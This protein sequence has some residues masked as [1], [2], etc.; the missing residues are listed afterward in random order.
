MSKKVYLF[1]LVLLALAFTGCSETE[2]V[3]KYDNWQS[4]NE[5]FID[6]IA[7]VHADLTT[8]GNLDSIHMI[9]YPGVPVYFK[10]KTPVGDGVIQN[11][12][13]RATD[14]VIVY[15]KGSFI[16]WGNT[17]GYVDEQG[18][19]IGEVF[20]GSFTEANPS[21]DFSN[22]A[23][24]TV[25]GLVTGLSEVLQRRKIGERLEVYVPWQYGYGANDYTPINSPIT[26]PG[27][28]VLVFDI[29]MLECK[30]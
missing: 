27:H 28:S 2:E 29:Q 9:A 30:K 21:I 26:I 15:Y 6:S 8:R 18:N 19:F 24:F 11:T 22:T 7:N 3:G 16:N 4:R 1:S 13:P 20:D 23:K 17:G 25:K 12:V 10:K 5:S 14:E